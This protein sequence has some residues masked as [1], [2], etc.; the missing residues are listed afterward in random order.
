ML[1]GLILQGTGEHGV[2]PT[3]MSC[4][5]VSCAAVGMRGRG[6]IAVQLID[7]ILF[8][9]RAGESQSDCIQ[10]ELWCP[11]FAYCNNANLGVQPVHIHTHQ[12]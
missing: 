10:F 5:I 1:F 7:I 4:L 6:G 2:T 9:K 12:G 8:L 3:V 11:N